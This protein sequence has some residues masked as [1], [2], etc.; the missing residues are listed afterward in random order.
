MKV[1][2]SQVYTDNFALGDATHC[3]NCGEWLKDMPK[4]CPE[5]GKPIVQVVQIITDLDIN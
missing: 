3:G 1:K 5:C 4:F 2:P